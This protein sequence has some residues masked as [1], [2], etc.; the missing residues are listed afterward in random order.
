MSKLIPFTTCLF[1]TP[2]FPF[3]SLTCFK[4]KQGSP[5]FQEMLQIA[6]PDLS[7]E[8]EKDNER[9]KYAEYRYFQRACTRSTPFGLFAG[10][11]MGIIGEKTDIQLSDESTYKRSTRLDMN[12]IC[13]LTQ[14]IEKDKNVRK[15]LTYYLNTSIYHAGK[16]LRYVDY[17]FHKARRKYQIE[18][19]EDS[20]YLK[21]T[22]TMAADGIPF[23]QLATALT[24]DDITMNDA[25]EFVHTLIDAQVLVSELEPAVTNV[26]QLSTL[27]E[28][29][30]K[31][32]FTDNRLELLKTIHLHLSDIDRQPI[33]NTNAFY[34]E[35]I[36]KI[37]QTKV[38]TEEKYLFQTDLYKPTL[39]ATISRS[40]IKDI[41]QAIGFLNKI[42]RTS[43]QP[44]LAKF[45]N[46]FVKRYEE[47]E[48]PL[49]FVLD[50]ELG[51]GYA[52]NASG[53]I[54]PLI[55]DLVI[56]QDSSMQMPFSPNILQ[57]YLKT[58]QKGDMVIELTDEDV[59]NLE[60]KWDDLPLTLSVFCR[61]L[62]DN[63]HGRCTY[64]KS[65]SGSSAVNLLGRFCHLDEQILS[66]T[67]NIAQKEAES[68]PEVIF[69]EIV[70]LPEAR[71]GN[72]L[73]RPTLRPYE[74][75]YLAKASVSQDCEIRLN[76]LYV[77]VKDNRLVL[78]SKR[79]NKEI[80]PR[81]GTAHNYSGQNPL[82][83]YHFLCDMQHQTGRLGLG[84]YWSEAVQQFDYLPC[85][86]YKNCI[87]SQA[88]WIVNKKEIEP[89]AKIKNNT[90]LIEEIGKWREKRNIPQEVVLA[91]G[92]NELYINMQ[93]PLSICSWLS[94]V[95]KR[96]SFILEEV[97]FKPDSTVVR[98]R[99]GVYTNEFIF[100]FYNDMAKEQKSK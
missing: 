93:E 42:N 16:N 78:R 22:L 27:I 40:I 13:A 25:M 67:L 32:K 17:H 45:R 61:I 33:G 90:E 65:V 49:L 79:L 37:K 55:D 89:L 95:K 48:M 86:K 38:E 92:D 57:K 51:L 97:L 14:Q 72:I 39:S 15:Q 8:L 71:T 63:E 62:Q 26:E 1:R 98:S 80:I 64:I 23:L 81:L 77:S 60:E 20:E 43:T 11:S 3:E 19:I 68:N 21:Q 58:M 5:V 28:K 54:S 34:P 24:N 87:L 47:R 59:K 75:P 31:I 84:F 91:D 83:V 46:N 10:C 9:A 96:S 52:E 73:L 100:A 85:V 7:D 2:Y 88:R 36:K 41:Q 35:I 94:V 44:N 66:H 82:P 56:L 76:D 70:H 30:D 18:Q 99:E 50:N 12:Y 74:I 4:T 29:L 69:A 6:S 53:D